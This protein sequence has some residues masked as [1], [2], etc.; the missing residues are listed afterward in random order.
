MLQANPTDSSVI[1]HYQQKLRLKNRNMTD[2]RQ[3]PDFRLK[4]MNI[5]MLVSWVVL[6]TSLITF[7][8]ARPEFIPGYAKYKE[9]ELMFRTEWDLY[10]SNI[11]FL[12]L[13]ICCFVSLTA[14]GINQTR[15][16]RATDHRRFNQILA[17]IVSITA[18][19]Y[20]WLEVLV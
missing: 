3:G 19:V 20:I 13:M 6:L 4:F 17:F 10:L 11:L 7:E 14:I 8:F 16:K 18:C 15:L 12:E 1:S 9:M 2:R 5:L